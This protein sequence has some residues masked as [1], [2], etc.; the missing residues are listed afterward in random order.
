MTALR[1]MIFNV[2]LFSTTF[3]L[4][5]P[6]TVLRF[7][8]PHRMLAFAKLWARLELAAARVICGIRLEVTGRENLPAGPALIASRH[9]SAFDILAWTVLTPLPCFV[10]KRELTAL[11]IF[12][13]LIL[14]G[15]MISVDREAGGAAL[16]ALLREG[17][18]AKA[19]GRQIVIFP[20]GT[21]V[22]PGEHP[23]LQPGAAALAA[24]TGLP[25]IPVT[26]N[27]GRFWG[28]RAFRKQA[29]T[30]HIV[31]HPPILGKP[32]REALLRTLHAIFDPDGSVDKSVSENPAKASH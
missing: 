20:E 15:G 27:S 26:T 4:A 25:V 30:I 8:A 23:P 21:R 24:K 19:E 12:G 11:P 32:G 28:R 17:E 13:P 1:S 16:R 5:I 29:G 10:V 2:F 31:I 14:L 7:T 6:G 9:E 18:R 3:L 22:D